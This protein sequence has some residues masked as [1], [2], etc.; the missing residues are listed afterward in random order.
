MGALE[1]ELESESPYLQFNRVE[2]RIRS[3][4]YVTCDIF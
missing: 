2:N 3:V 4:F 1:E